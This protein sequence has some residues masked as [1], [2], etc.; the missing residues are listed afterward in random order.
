MSDSKKHPQINFRA[1]R[2]L[3]DNF[4]AFLLS[5][6]VDRTAFFTQV[7]K[8]AVAGAKAGSDHAETSGKSASKKLR[9]KQQDVSEEG[10]DLF[11]MLMSIV[12]SGNEVAKL[13][14]RGAIIC[15][16][17]LVS[18]GRYQDIKGIL[19]EA[20]HAAQ[21]AAGH[22]RHEAKAEGDGRALQTGRGAA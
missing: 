19:A 4:D 2:A 8:D 17:A 1:E 11:Q 9:K 15:S 12:T 5:Q 13:G 10:L 18:N 3:R 7:M 22:P 16:A 14:A 20:R 6:R 21:D